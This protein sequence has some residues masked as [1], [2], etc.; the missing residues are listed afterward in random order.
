MV[1]LFLSRGADPSALTDDG[2]TA[3]DIAGAQGHIEI[4]AMLRAVAST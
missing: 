3:A 4:A 2:K 1:E